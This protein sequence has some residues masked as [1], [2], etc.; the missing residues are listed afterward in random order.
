MS[1]PITGGELN[2]LRAGD[3]CDADEPASGPVVLFLHGASFRATTWIETG[4]LEALC[5]AGIPGLAVDLPGFGDTPRFG[6][7][8]ATL[9]D[10]VVDYIAA[11]VVV[12]SPSMSGNYTLPW[13]MT[14]PVAAAGFVP[15]APVGI[16]TWRTPEGFAVPTLGF[17]GEDDR[18]VP[19]DQGRSL[20]AAI[21]DAELRVFE[22]AG[23]AVYMDE[24]ERFNAELV[25]WIR[26]L[27]G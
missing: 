12:V 14:K 3:L 25:E 26:N 15:V 21:P 18:V 13:L 16:S 8:P 5:R 19:V 23:H 6:H 22:G 4:T 27:P 24:P 7:D 20:V 11:D 9:L 1:I 10:E 17:W 2:A